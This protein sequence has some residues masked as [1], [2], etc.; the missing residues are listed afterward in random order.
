[1]PRPV[2][3]RMEAEL[4]AMAESQRDPERRKRL[5][6][7][8]DAGHGSCILGRNAVAALVVETWQRFAGER[9]GLGAWVIMPNHV[10]VLIRI[11]PGQ[12]LARIVGSWKSYTAKRIMAMTGLP[13]PI[14][15]PDYW[16]RFIRD[17]VHWLATRSY[18]ERNPVAAGL[19]ADPADWRWGSAAG[20]P[21]GPRSQE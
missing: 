12:P 2:L 1:M 3:A 11:R 5:E 18:I 16:D 7:W 4:S 14:W 9:Y 17:Q 13:A 21:S 10:H 8:M 6:A 15:W 20:R 19:V